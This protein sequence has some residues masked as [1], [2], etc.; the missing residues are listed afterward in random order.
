M[1]SSDHFAAFAALENEEAPLLCLEDDHWVRRVC[2]TRLPDESVDVLRATCVALSGNDDD[3]AA[4]AFEA[5]C[6]AVAARSSTTEAVALAKRCGFDVRDRLQEAEEGDKALLCAFLK[7]AQVASTIL[8]KGKG[9]ARPPSRGARMHGPLRTKKRPRPSCGTSTPVSMMR[10]T[11]P[12]K[13]FSA[14]PRG[15]SPILIRT[16]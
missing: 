8:K 2:V 3:D 7:D 16:R 12:S 14:R 5:F 6:A 11:R 15:G 10:T 9:G 1:H 4:F 13:R